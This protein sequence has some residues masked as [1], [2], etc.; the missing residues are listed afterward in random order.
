M[1]RWIL[2]LL[3]AM[4]MMAMAQA[5]EE[6]TTTPVWTGGKS[7]AEAGIK[8]DVADVK[9]GP[10]ERNVL[11]LYFPAKKSDKPMPVLVVIHGG[12][13]STGDKGSLKVSV[14]NEARGAGIV[15]AAIN[16]R[17]ST[18]APA[19]APFL[20]GAR[21][22]QFLRMKA[23]EWNLDPQ[24][25]ALSGNSAGAGISLWMAF[26]DDLADPA[27][28]DSMLRESTRV[29]CVYAIAAQT[30]YEPAWIKANVPG[31]AWKHAAIRKLF[32]LKEGEEVNPPAEKTKLMKEYAPI[33]LVKKDSP[34][35][36]M[37]Y[38]QD[39]SA[40]AGADSTIHHPK[41]GDLLKEKM[42][43]L[44]I[45]CEVRVKGEAVEKPTPIEFLKRHLKV[46]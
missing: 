44:K 3:L 14:L 18:I 10:H 42:D 12:G 21:A 20:D 23:K 7:V 6:A 24:R 45:Q 1:M 15:V 11:D 8:A 26:H 33:E 46:E 13:F 30:S 28:G 2:V 34:P 39:R 35:V 43:A 27:N 41:F 4:S 29:T 40:P 19:P 38:L 9:Y 31:D 36:Y 25:F 32:D 22:V 16:Y 5:K 17:Y 37:L